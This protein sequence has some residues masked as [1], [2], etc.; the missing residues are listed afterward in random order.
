MSGGTLTFLPWVRQ[1]AA[2][3]LTTVDP[4]IAANSAGELDARVELPVVVGLHSNGTASGTEATTKLR[5]YGPGDIHGIDPKQIIRT[6]PIPNTTNFETNYFPLVEFDRPD[7]PWLFTPAAAQS[8]GKLRPWLC[9]IVVRADKADIAIQPTRPLP[10][11]N[12]RDAGTE[13]PDLSESWAWAHAQIAGNDVAAALSAGPERTLSRLICPRRLEPR[14]AYIAALVPTFGVGV[15]A[16]LGNPVDDK[17]IGKLS[18]AWTASATTI[19]LPAYFH[20]TFATGEAGDFEELVSQLKRVPGNEI[21]GFGFRDM[22]ITQAGAQLPDVLDNSVPPRPKPIPVAGALVPAGLAAAQSPYPAAFLS[23]LNNLL[24][25]SESGA[26]LPGGLPIAPPLYG[27]WHAAQSGIPVNPAPGARDAQWLRDL[28]LNP[29][30]RIAAAL[31]TRV[32]QERQEDLM[33]SAWQQVGGIELAN[34]LLKQAQLARDSSRERFASLSAMS[35]AALLLLGGPTLSRVKVDP[36]ANQPKRLSASGRVELSRV[37]AAAT[38]G[39]FRR[40]ARPRGP[41][42]KRIGRAGGQVDSLAARLLLRLNGNTRLV[43]NRPTPSGR[44]SIDAA[45]AHLLGPAAMKFCSI[46]ER[47]LTLRAKALDIAGAFTRTQQALYAAFLQHQAAMAPCK[48]L[49]PPPLQPA[50]DIAAVAAALRARLNPEVSIP[51]VINARVSAPGWKRPDALAPVLAAPSFPT[52]MFR[53]L[54]NVSQDFV[55]AGLERLPKNSITSAETNPAFIAA[56]MAGLNHEMMRELL[57][58]EFPTDQRGTCFRQFWDPF[59]RVPTPETPQQLEAARDIALIP[60]WSA[61]AALGAAAVNPAAPVT[62]SQIVL[63]IR[64]ELI[65]RYSRA[66]TYVVKGEWYNAAATGAAAPVWRRR[67]TTASPEQNEHYP[68]FQGTLS[69]DVTFLGFA[70]TTTEALG[71]G[72]DAAGN[73]LDDQGNPIADPIA[74]NRAGWFVVLQQQHSEPRF[75]LD[76]SGTPTASR[77]P[78]L[79]WSNVTVGPN[80]HLKLGGALIDADPAFAQTWPPANGAQLAKGTLQRPFRAAIHLSDLLGVVSP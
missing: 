71:R 16:G 39:A 66:T 58:R 48:S 47:Q 35:D 12:V 14:T 33:T 59:T 21:P 6:D 32:V 1:G 22:L 63:V 26:A 30:L 17:T 64:G 41:L 51:A 43:P 60:E 20:W 3:L 5:L 56:Y 76:E 55:L 45:M 74:D 13:L 38:T 52:P 65:Q 75:G 69:P 23:A 27:R 34:Q 2:S 72:T 53:A 42:A 54:A 10:H 70:L 57:W 24:N 67:P 11:I 62:A 68:Q 36:D 28:N 73:P 79:G 49:E 29:H 25:A 8:D 40:A 31:G 4:I 44:M 78:D 80:H 19:D 61:S 9:L 46:D 15:T 18:P 77:W 37:P 7:F 50:L